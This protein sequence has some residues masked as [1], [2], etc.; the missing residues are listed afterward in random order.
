MAR[1]SIVVSMVEDNE[2]REIAYTLFF[3]GLVVLLVWLFTRYYYKGSTGR[4]GGRGAASSGSDYFNEASDRSGS[5]LNIDFEE[6]DDED[7]LYQSAKAGSHIRIPSYFRFEAKDLV[8]S[9][10]LSHFA[11]LGR[12]VREAAL[13]LRFHVLACAFFSLISVVTLTVLVPIYA[14]SP[15]NAY[16]PYYRVSYVEKVTATNLSVASGRLL[17]S[18]IA[19]V[20]FAGIAWLWIRQYYND[21]IQI[22]SVERESSGNAS[23]SALGGGSGERAGGGGV[24]IDAR[25]KQQVVSHTILLSGLPKSLTQEQLLLKH[26]KLTF[27]ARVLPHRHALWAQQAPRLFPEPPG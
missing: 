11:P 27:G 18:Y 5:A 13:Y 8:F 25:G 2:L 4:G 20:M 19:I 23:A 22:V 16:S 12:H 26:L 10:F 1:S 15:G 17:V 24:S 7:P 9:T 3:D 14:Q 21:I 6:E